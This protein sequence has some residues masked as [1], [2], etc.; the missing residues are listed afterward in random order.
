MS[1]VNQNDG[2]RYA[3]QGEE[4][5]VTGYVIVRV[6]VDFCTS[7]EEGSNA[8]EDDLWDAMD[9]YRSDIEDRDL[10]IEIVEREWRD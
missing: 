3:D 1:H 7:Y 9:L 5:H 8:F 4:Y 6:P 2:I 10:E